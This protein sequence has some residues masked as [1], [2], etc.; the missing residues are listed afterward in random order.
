MTQVR[1]HVSLVAATAPDAVAI[2]SSAAMLTYGELDTL[3]SRVTGSLRQRHIV[4]GDRIIVRLPRCADLFPVLLGV[5]GA[6]AAFVPVDE[7]A[8]ADRLRQI[9][10]DCSP[11]LVVTTR[12]SDLKNV[13]VPVTT[14]GEL[15]AHDTPAPMI[16]EA[17][18]AAYVLY[19]SG[20][21]GEPK[22][23]VVGAEAMH[24]Y[25]QWARAEYAMDG[26]TGAPLFTSSAFD[27]TL[28]TLFGPLLA[29]RSVT[30]LG[31]HD[32]VLE[33]A[34]LLRTRPDFSFVKATPHHVRLLTDLLQGQ[35]L[36]RAMRRL[37][38][39]GD[40]LDTATVR[41]WTSVCPVPV[42][43]EYG[44]TETV[45]GCT[46]FTVLPHE[47]ARLGATVPIGRG[48]AESHVYVLDDSGE[49]VAAGRVGELFV[50][51]PSADNYYLGR[52]AIT[53]ARFVPDPFAGSGARMYR[54]GDLAS[55]LPDGVLEFHGRADRQVKVRGFRVELGEIETAVRE[56]PRV[57]DAAAFVDRT[58]Q[59]VATAVVYTGDVEPDQVREDLLRRVPAWVVPT[60]IVRTDMLPTTRNA[61]ADLAG[62]AALV[63]ADRTSAARPPADPL[64]S[65]DPLTSAVMSEFSAVLAGADIAPDSD[66]FQCGGDSMSGIRL[67]ARLRRMGHDVTPTDLTA[68]PSPCRL[69]ALLYSRGASTSGALQTQV[70]E[71]VELTPVQRDFFALNLPVPGH[72]NQQTIVAARDGFDRDRLLASLDAVA[73][74]HEVLRYRFRSGRQIH[75][76]GPPAVEFREVA[77]ADRSGLADV[78]RDAHADLDLADG[79]L[80]RWVLVRINGAPD[81]LVLVAHHLVVDEVSW[82]VL[83]DDLAACYR[84]GTPDVARPRSRDFAGWRAA[85]ARFVDRPDVLARRG[86]WDDVMATPVGRLGDKCGDHDDYGEEHN[87]SGGLDAAVTSRLR[88]A[89]DSAR[90]GVHE[91]LLGGVVGALTEVFEIAPPRVDVETHGRVDLGAGVDA[92]RIM[93]WCTAVFPVVLR[94]ETTMDLVRSARDVL[95]ALAWHGIEFGLLRPSHAAPSRSSQVLFNYLG[96]RDRV[97]DRDL[98]WTLVDP[99][100]GAESP[101]AGQRPYLLEFQSRIMDGGIRWEWRAG[102]HHSALVVRRLSGQLRDTLAAVA[103]ELDADLTI[104]YA[105]SGLSRSD[106][107]EVLAQYSAPDDGTHR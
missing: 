34:K 3:A 44:P 90:V 26:G 39:G 87:V 48:V 1:G 58:A 2:R 95:G 20:T 45:V 57:V 102:S 104:R 83:L 94:G 88:E 76:G 69:A 71:E 12:P 22:G 18:R 93:G 68:S 9:V 52:P 64:P 81:H 6:G 33:L 10:R 14:P 74:Q 91:I 16:I 5:L 98:G 96:E 41:A 43:N 53:A 79:P 38:I 105:A 28:T 36:E 75:V 17:D 51:G 77:I 47:I 50:A 80:A 11:T 35:R 72:W 40:V 99:V 32:P 56:T 23:V 31:E 106:L 25:L 30:V 49:P 59:D 13:A 8:P 107:A 42:V 19:T 21:T 66:F 54:T 60:R 29:G 65:V 89:A 24:R 67:V 92:S 103:D 100:P 63:S 62:L 37:V 61:K 86:Y 82:N 97:L 7:A 15:M 78:V 27:A 73:G 85:L 55:V 4:E 101:P 84:S 70:G 46:A